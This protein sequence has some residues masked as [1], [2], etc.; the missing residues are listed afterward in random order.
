MVRE[1]GGGSNETYT[2]KQTSM[3]QVEMTRRL[4]VELRNFNR[5]TTRFSYVLVFLTVVQIL[6]ALN[7][8]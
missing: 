6:L 4:I 8:C 1:S 7:H 5:T 2:M 3:R